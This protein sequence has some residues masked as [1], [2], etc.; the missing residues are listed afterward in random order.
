MNAFGRHV[1]SIGIAGGIMC[2]LAIE[3]GGVEFCPA[4]CPSGKVPL[5]ISAPTSGPSAAF[6]RQAVKSAEI[7]IHE[8]NA[9]GGLT[10]IPVEPVVDD[11]R[12]D[13]GLAASV[14]KRQVEKEKI[15]AVIAEG[16]R[17]DLASLPEHPL[18]YKKPGSPE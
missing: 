17:V 13:P 14:A 4:H 10:G 6:G 5:G 12:C 8:M 7:A 9:A 15:A 1:V 16:R 11:D 18:F 3:S 2:A